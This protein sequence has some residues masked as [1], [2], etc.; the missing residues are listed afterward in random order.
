MRYIGIDFGTKRFGISISD[1]L[2]LS[3]QGY[4][5]INAKLKDLLALLKELSEKHGE[6]TVVVGLPTTL[7]GK[8]SEST[9]KVLNFVDKLRQALKRMD[10]KIE[11]DTYDE[12][13]STVAAERTLIEAGLS[14]QK[15]KKVIDS[16]AAA[17]MLQGYIERIKK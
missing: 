5:V 1:P 6:I 11:V 13:F 14:R 2:L 4:A 8:V 12:R 17:F 9:Q 10:K 3:A 16:Q 15:R 7:R